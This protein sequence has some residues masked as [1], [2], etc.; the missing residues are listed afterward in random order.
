MFAAS[1]ER[2]IPYS[3]FAMKDRGKIDKLPEGNR[4]LLLK[5]EGSATVGLYNIGRRSRSPEVEV[6]DSMAGESRV[7]DKK[8]GD[9]AIDSRR[10]YSNWQICVITRGGERG[11]R[12][13]GRERGTRLQRPF[14]AQ[15]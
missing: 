10:N 3:V 15:S 1:T 13:G 6:E 14:H 5:G 11:L 9:G 12:R 8:I 7:E 4:E 2:G